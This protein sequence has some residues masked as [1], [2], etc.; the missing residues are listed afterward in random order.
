[1][2]LYR[3]DVTEIVQ[4]ETCT[5]IARNISPIIS[6]NGELIGRAAIA[7][8]HPI[9]RSLRLE[10]AAPAE[11]TAG[12]FR[13]RGTMDVC[14]LFIGSPSKASRDS[15]TAR[16]VSEGMPLAKWATDQARL[17]TSLTDDTYALCE[18][19]MLIRRFGGDTCRLPIFRDRE[20]FKSFD[21]IA[22]Q[23]DLPDRLE[24]V[25]EF[26]GV[27]TWCPTELKHDQLGVGSGRMKRL[28]DFNFVRDPRRRAD[29]PVWDRFWMSPWGAAMEAVAHAWKVPLRE[30]LDAGT[31]RN[32]EKLSN[33]SIRVTSDILIHP[34]KADMPNR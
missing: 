25:Q 10:L 12:Q 16:A 5:Q 18:M 28:H 23:A 21:Q 33:G 8:R 30:V 34:R 1:L 17:V 22:S 4:D 29:H 13:S 27:A 31:F 6:E 15:S 2:L 7:I 19:A 11:V 9:G 24:L 3:D 20:G 26:W 14:G 32:D